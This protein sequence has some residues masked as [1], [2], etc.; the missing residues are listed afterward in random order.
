MT[1]EAWTTLAV[2]AAVVATLVIRQRAP[3]AT[4]LGGLTLL[5]VLPVR[6]EGTW[7]FGVL[8]VSDGLSGFAN[9]GVVVLGALFVVAAG[10]RETG[11]V[12]WIGQRLL[13][14][15]KS[16]F[17]AQ[18]RIMLPT[19][20]MSA[21]MNNTPVVAMLLPVIG[22]WSRKH[23]LA[24]SH[25][26]LPLSFASIF[27]GACTLIGTSTN[28]IVANWLSREVGY[29]LGMFEIAKV[30]LPCA[31]LGLLFVLAF[32][33]WLLPRRGEII[34]DLQDTR[35]YTVEMVVD[36][37]GP[38]VGRTIEQ[39]G[40]RHLPGMYL[41]EIDRGGHL[42]PA[43]S[44]TESLHAS[45]RLVFVGVVESVVDLQK[46][47]GL[48]PAPDQ[49]FKLDEPRT[50]RTLVE[51]VVSDSCPVA[52]QTIRGGR[53][54]SRYNAV[55][56]AVSRNGRRIRR[57]VGDIVLHAGDTLLLE[58]GPGFIE[59]QRN[60]RDF[61]LVSSVADS[62][63]PRH[64]RAPLAMLI[65]GL[66]V[67]AVT[68]N[69]LSM[70]QASLVAGILM[71]LTRCCTASV[72]RRSVDWQV[73]VLI[74]AALGIGR[75]MQTTGLA[76]SIGIELLNIT[77]NQPMMAL[78]VI[79]GLTIVLSNVITAKAA[80]V[81]MLPLALAA[82]QGVDAQPMPFVMV[83]MIGAATSLATPVVYPT[84]LMVYGPGGYRF[85]DYLR[86]GVPLHV[87]LGIATLW[88]TPII[89]PFN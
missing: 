84:N 77:G 27:G 85:W 78:V 30:G 74:G 67:I 13:G 35:Q 69:W 34:D 48:I 83:V 55:V 66:M 19:A 44:P 49:L 82:S 54:R 16:M 11:A 26:L 45:D 50:Q 65:L 22:D 70:L 25:L 75:A 40:L 73:L 12:S 33:R 28:V 38:L 43:V 53:F 72:A 76:Q 52:Q 59:Q 32:G 7:R 79:Y 17:S 8:D 80:A 62:T 58:T 20:A 51:A 15:P 89:W 9:P 56:I 64:E 3:D 61:Y 24:A 6:I 42:I 57:K 86:I 47:R 23:R 87:L 31:V 60:S 68:A 5:L 63:P 14:R 21:F 39:A 10:L 88:L 81:L 1:P 36:E 71:I 18:L 29:D 2:L 41:M 37:A 46:I 4:M